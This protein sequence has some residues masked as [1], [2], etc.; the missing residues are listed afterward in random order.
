[1]VPFVYLT[2]E[3]LIPFSTTVSKSENDTIEFVKI[4]Q[5]TLDSDDSYQVFEF[6]SKVGAIFAINTGNRFASWQIGD[7]LNAGTKQFLV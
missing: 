1:M 5:K 2:R 3:T 6:S 7:I 4:V